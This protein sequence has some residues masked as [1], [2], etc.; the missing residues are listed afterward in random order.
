[1]LLRNKIVVGILYWK[2]TLKK[3][4]FSYF[5]FMLYVHFGDIP[6]PVQYVSY[7]E[8]YTVRYIS[9]TSFCCN[10]TPMSLYKIGVGTCMYMYGI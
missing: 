7:H 2:I 6:V 5:K 9:S 8:V 3:L 10:Y 4:V 1:M